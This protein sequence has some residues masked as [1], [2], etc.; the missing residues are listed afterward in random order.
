[1]TGGPY[2]DLM[3]SKRTP[4]VVEMQAENDKL[5]AENERLTQALEKITKF[6]AV[7]PDFEFC[8]HPWC[9]DSCGAVLTALDALR[10]PSEG[11]DE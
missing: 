1:M 8:V 2:D 7:C 3:R 5:R 4:V 9:R 10:S 11:A 6:G